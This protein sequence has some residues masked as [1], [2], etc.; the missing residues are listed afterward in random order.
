MADSLSVAPTSSPTG[1]VVAD[2]IMGV[3]TRLQTPTAVEPRRCSTAPFC[4]PVDR[5][6]VLETRTVR[7]PKYPLLIVRD[8]TGQVSHEISPRERRSVGPGVWTIECTSTAVKTYLH[9]EGAFVTDTDADGRTV[10]ATEATRFR[11]GVRSRHEQPAATVTAP[12][13]PAG[14]AAALSQFG[15]ALKTTSPER[16]WPTLRGHPP[17]VE[18]G[19]ELH[20]PESLTVGR[21]PPSLVV[22]VPPDLSYL[23]PVAS[24]AF[25]LDA[26]VELGSTPRLRADAHEW[27]YSLDGPPPGTVD[28]TSPVT[29]PADGDTTE[30]RP[31][32]ERV[33]RT[34]QQT[35]VLDCVARTEGLYPFDLDER[36]RVERRLA[37]AGYPLDFAALYDASLA[38][39]T[40]AYLDVPFSVVAAAVPRWKLTADVVPRYDSLNHLPFVVDDLGVVR[41]LSGTPRPEP[42]PERPA[43]DAFVRGGGSPPR[44]TD[45]PATPADA[46][47][48]DGGVTT[49]APG[50]VDRTGDTATPPTTLGE[51]RVVVPRAT[52]S[53]EH[54]WVGDGYPVGA[55]KPVLDA[56]HRRLDATASGDIQVAV[57][58]NDPAMLDEL[59]VSNLYG[60]RDLV[61]FDVDSYEETTRAELAALLATDLDFLHYIGHVDERGMQC[62]D[63]YLDA[64]SLDGVNVRAFMLNACRSYVQAHHLV[65]AGAIGGLATVENVENVAAT[66]LGRTLARLLNAGFSLGGALDVLGSETAMGGQYLVVGDHNL[67]VAQCRS[68]CPVRVAVDRTGERFETTVHAYPTTAVNIGS[69]YA[70]TV[71]DD[72]DRRYLGSG[73]MVSLPATRSQVEEL[74]ALERLPVSLRGEQGVHWSDDLSVD[75]I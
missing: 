11:V 25:F 47:R 31:F 18:R 73:P 52:D 46:C 48:S 39:R 15:S 71:H 21:A 59:D 27:T 65:D 61:A 42:S 51:E 75:D 70:P 29:A 4:L 3:T 32:E 26:R 66:G 8:G 22:E 43:I 7:L 54:V 14:V 60:L 68:G 19:E 36:R 56:S 64:A 49:D 55:T 50:G 53:I 44:S 41:C 34:L 24:L 6:V 23:Y 69:I 67:T 45:G 20:V 10:T 40:M 33:A 2:D 62:A 13:T 74:F 16:T 1:V 57:V 5:A 9:V 38:E 30:T 63:G 17:L 72:D 28:A 58:A 35:F 37:E 12:E